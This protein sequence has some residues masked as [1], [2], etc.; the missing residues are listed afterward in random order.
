MRDLPSKDKSLYDKDIYKE[1]LERN[2][3][4]SQFVALGGRY[5]EED[6]NI[7]FYIHGSAFIPHHYGLFKYPFNCDFEY[8]GDPFLPLD[9][10]EIEQKVYFKRDRS[11]GIWIEED[12]K[13]IRIKLKVLIPKE[14]IGK[15]SSFKIVRK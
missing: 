12:P 8:Q 13:C 2:E 6:G 4:H 9:C 5:K 15:Y 3:M 10:G 11:K 1:E 14:E 7:G